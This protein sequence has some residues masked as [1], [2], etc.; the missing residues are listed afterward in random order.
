MDGKLITKSTI[1]GRP[2][3]TDAA[4]K[5]FL[6]APDKTKP[7]PNYGSGPPMC[8]YSPERVE[9]AEQLEDFAAWRAKSLIRSAIRVKVSEERAAKLSA[10][11]A[12]LT[13]TVPLH[14]DARHLAIVSYNEYREGSPHDHDPASPKS[15]RSFLDRITVNYL[16][17]EATQYD[18]ILCEIAGNPGIGDAYE[19]LFEK[20]LQAIAHQYPS[21]RAE[22]ARQIQTKKAQ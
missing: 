15:D 8:L 4:I 14:H 6:G 22:C 12:G 1:K 13:V 18:D 17:H 2:G 3:W 9:K 10:Y 20:V 7:N 21:L 16:R 5:K 19:A 11:V